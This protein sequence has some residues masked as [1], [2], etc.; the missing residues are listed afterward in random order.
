MDSVGRSAVVLKSGVAQSVRKYAHGAVRP[1]HDGLCAVDRGDSSSRRCRPGAAGRRDLNGAL[2]LACAVTLQ[3]GIGIVTLLY[4]APLPLAL[5]HQ[6]TGI[7]VLSIAMIHA[8]RLSRRNATPAA[9]FAA[10][11]VMPEAT[12]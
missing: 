7:V 1:P 3:A 9:Q 10:G 2:A 5:L 4:Q 11:A 6:V 8:E 12:K